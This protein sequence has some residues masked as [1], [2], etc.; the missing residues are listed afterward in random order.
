MEISQVSIFLENRAGGLADVIDVLAENGIDIRALALADMADFGILRLIVDDPDRTRAVLKAAGFTAD[1]TR[2]VAIEVPDKPGGLAATLRSLRQGK[3]NVEYM[4]SATP[5]KSG[6][7]I[8]IFRFDELDRALDVLRE[9]GV[10]IIP[11]LNA[12]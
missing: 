8:L 6:R 11:S 10:A 4:Y 7:A 12:V 9:A 3:V 1:K 2:V 5:T